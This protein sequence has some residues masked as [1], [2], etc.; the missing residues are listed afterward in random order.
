MSI[1]AFQPHA[2]N[3][4]LEM[5]VLPWKLKGTKPIAAASLPTSC[6]C[7][8]CLNLVLD[9]CRVDGAGRPLKASGERPRHR[10]IMEAP[11]QTIEVAMGPLPGNTGRPPG[12]P[13]SGDR[14]RHRRVSP[15]LLCQ[16]VSFILSSHMLCV[17]T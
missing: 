8:S 14:H 6:T 16:A 7:V 11:L 15:H 3:P 13:G 17:A 1:L 12:R 2:C 4:G 9:D 10:A 5:G